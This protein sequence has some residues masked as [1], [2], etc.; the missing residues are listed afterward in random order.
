M[1]YRR[2]SIVYFALF[3]ACVVAGTYLQGGW[4]ALLLD[5][6]SPALI[7]LA[8]VLLL[9][10]LGGTQGAAHAFFDAYAVDGLDGRSERYVQD[11]A[12]IRRAGSLLFLWGA[13]GALFGYFMLINNLDED[14]HIGS[15]IFFSLS[16]LWFMLVIRLLL[17]HP[18]LISL[19]SKIESLH[20]SVELDEA[21]SPRRE[22]R[23]WVY[24]VMLFML[25]V[26]SAV[27]FLA[28]GA[29]IRI[30]IIPG[31]AMFVPFGAAF[32]AAMGIGLRQLGSAFAIAL[33]NVPHAANEAAR[34]SR[35]LQRC[36]I[37]AIEA[38]VTGFVTKLTIMLAIIE[39]PEAILGQFVLGLVPV[40]Y[41]IFVAAVFCFPLAHRLEISR[42]RPEA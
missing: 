15:A 17:V 12:L 23:P 3:L 22:L 38:G 21:D 5:Y 24:L 28:V 33:G 26:V 6:R 9:L 2:S 31:A 37:M 4:I 40:F 16:T 20:S 27:F 11:R 39:E 8:F 42:R 19:E 18:T 14:V 32:A 13:L 35:I 29:D 10:I 30:L 25:P 7:F 36:G 1:M 41:G 34:A